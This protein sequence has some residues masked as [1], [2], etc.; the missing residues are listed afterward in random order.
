MPSH[1]RWSASRSGRQ[2]W[3]SEGGDR[4]RAAAS[5]ADQPMG[6]APVGAG[7]A[8]GPSHWPCRPLRPLKGL[9]DEVRPLSF[10]DLSRLRAE[11]RR[12]TSR[13]PCFRCRHRRSGWYG[14]ESSKRRFGK[15]INGPH[16]APRLQCKNAPA[17]AVG[18]ELLVND[19]RVKIEGLRTRCHDFR[20][21]R[22]Y[23]TTLSSAS[24]GLP[25]PGTAPVDVRAGEGRVPA[26][27]RVSWRHAFRSKPACGRGHRLIS[28]R[29]QSVGS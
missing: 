8:G 12:V 2:G 20:H 27:T 21:A 9:P 22:C 4:E 19:H 18:D 6:L 5:L 25:P 23:S 3:L 29:I 7:L 13:A 15:R 14:G 24:R 16:G 28:R 17:W 11:G 1:V 10:E 26:Q